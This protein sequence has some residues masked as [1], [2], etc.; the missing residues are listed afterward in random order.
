[1]KRNV[2]IAQ[3]RAWHTGDDQQISISS[4]GSAAGMGPR[5]PVTLVWSGKL[6]PSVVLALASQL[7]PDVLCAPRA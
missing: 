4:S 1:M 7:C 2:Y 6:R 5:N 3:P